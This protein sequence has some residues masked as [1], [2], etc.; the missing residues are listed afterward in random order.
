[1]K[2]VNALLLTLGIIGL[3]VFLFQSLGS[4]EPPTPNVTVGDTEIPTT[5]GSYC[6]DGLF[7][8]K[9]VD[10]VY[11]SGWDMGME[12]EPVKV[13]PNEK[14]NV[15]FDKEPLENSLFVEKWT[16]EEEVIKIEMKNNTITAPAESGVYVYLIRANWKQGDG[17]YAFAVKVE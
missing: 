1:M 12:H 6:W 15:E 13:S 7:S 4:T 17:S 5:Q 14:I 16:D 10:M 8:A 9:C 2:K 3:G 11:T